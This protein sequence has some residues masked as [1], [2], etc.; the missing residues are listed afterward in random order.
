MFG[1]ARF[2]VRISQIPQQDSLPVVVA[3]L[4]IQRNRFLRSVD[5][6]SIVTQKVFCGRKRLPRQSLTLPISFAGVDSRRRNRR[7]SRPV[8]IAQPVKQQPRFTVQRRSLQHSVVAHPKKIGR[9]TKFLQRHRP[10]GPVSMTAKV[11]GLRQ[12][13]FGRRGILIRIHRRPRRRHADGPR[14]RQLRMETRHFEFFVRPATT[15]HDQKFDRRFQPGVIDPWKMF[16]SVSVQPANQKHLL[17]LLEGNADT[18]ARFTLEN[19]C[20][21]LFGRELQLLALRRCKKNCSL[22]SSRWH[23]LCCPNAAP[24]SENRRAH[25]CARKPGPR[26]QTPSSAHLRG[27]FHRRHSS[28]GPRFKHNHP[29]RQKDPSGISRSGVHGEDRRYNAEAYDTC[30]TA[31]TRSLRKPTSIRLPFRRSRPNSSPNSSAHARAPD[32]APPLLQRVTQMP[33]RLFQP[34]LQRR[35]ILGQRVEF[36]LRQRSGLGHLM[37]RPIRSAHCRANARRHFRQS[38]LLS[39]D[40]LQIKPQSS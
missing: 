1:I 38:G 20:L 30:D 15:T 10:R 23:A 26:I 5:P 27:Q 28:L 35:H 22:R 32:S 7:V 16:R 12:R 40:F 21:A 4:L 31:A 6:R 36:L 13:I 2:P 24:P 3:R 14:A 34:A 8:I 39:H 29:F 25:Q 19:K 18:R 37:R 33:R 17:R 11:F 9:P